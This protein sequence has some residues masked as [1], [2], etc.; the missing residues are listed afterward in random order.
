[1]ESGNAIDGGVA[2]GG[3]RMLCQSS[4]RVKVVVAFGWAIILIDRS[5]TCSID[6]QKPHLIEHSGYKRVQVLR[7][8]RCVEGNNRISCCHER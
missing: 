2:D 1:M 3:Y 8:I 7:R 4:N 6:V 5:V